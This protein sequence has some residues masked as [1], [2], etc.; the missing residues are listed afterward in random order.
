MLT[1]PTPTLATLVPARD[2]RRDLW[3][4][5]REENRYGRAVSGF[6]AAL[7]TRISLYMRESSRPAPRTTGPAMA[8]YVVAA[9]AASLPDAL[10]PANLGGR[11]PAATAP[12]RPSVRRPAARSARPGATSGLYR[13]RSFAIVTE[14]RAATR[15]RDLPR[16]TRCRGA[17]SNGIRSARTVERMIAWAVPPVRSGRF[18]Y[19]LAA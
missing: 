12:A 7:A 13:S 17:Y 11:A 4:H 9:P 19:A 16:V 6:Y 1:T 15:E 5:A 18:R 3:R 14:V 8:T 10:S 2:R